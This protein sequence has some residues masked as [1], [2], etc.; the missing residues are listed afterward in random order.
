MLWVPVDERRGDGLSL[1]PKQHIFVQCAGRQHNHDVLR[2]PDIPIPR[3]E[4]AEL[5]PNNRRSSSLD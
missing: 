1:L 4:D 2:L 3:Y 5:Q